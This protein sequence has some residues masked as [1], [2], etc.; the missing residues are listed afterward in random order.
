MLF[1]AVFCCFLQFFCKFGK[2]IYIFFA[3]YI[4]ILYFPPRPHGDGQ[5]CWFE[6]CRGWRGFWRIVISIR[7]Y[8]V[9]GTFFCCLW[10]ID[11][12]PTFCMPTCRPWS[13]ETIL[14]TPHPPTYVKNQRFT[15][16]KFDNQWPRIAV[17]CAI[18]RKKI[19]GI[20]IDDLKTTVNLFKHRDRGSDRNFW[21]FE[22]RR[23]ITPSDRR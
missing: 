5:G 20:K 7:R 11:Q 13:Y 3:C 16:E 12:R 8:I 19:R 23:P 21:F 9:R 6:I 4:N 17:E 14:G 10:V 1:F 15:V 22:K 2:F 18:V